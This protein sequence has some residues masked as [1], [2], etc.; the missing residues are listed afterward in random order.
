MR[1]AT[2]EIAQNLVVSE[3]HELGDNEIL[4]VTVQDEACHYADWVDCYGAI[5]FVRR[6]SRS[7]QR[8]AGFDGAARKLWSGSDCFWWQPPSEIVNDPDAL[9][10]T[11][12]AVQN[13]VDNGIQMVTIEYCSGQ[14][15]YGRPIVSDFATLGAVE[16]Y[17]GDA[18]YRTY[19]VIGLLAELETSLNLTNVTAYATK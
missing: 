9:K 5:E 15:A 4:R 1:L 7:N 2:D 11:Q 16:W 6:G 18:E 10:I 8:P 13:L 14:D 3:T 17:G 19:I 12:R